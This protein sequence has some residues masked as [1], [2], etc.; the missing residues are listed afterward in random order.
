MMKRL[1]NI[2]KYALLIVFCILIRFVPR[3]PNVEPVMA[4]ILPVSKSHGRYAALIFGIFVMI[5]FDLLTSFGIW[6][7]ITAATYG[8]VGF[9]SAYYFKDREATGM[10]FIKFAIPATIAYDFITA[11]FSMLPFG[12]SLE[13]I[14]LG[15]I[16]FTIMH[17]LGNVALCFFVSPLLYRYITENKSIELS[18]ILQ[19]K[20]LGAKT[21]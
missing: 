3:I 16:P 5:I 4:S 12:M 2:F 1:N 19:R 14:W 10:N 9:V 21:A 6:T 17:L 8:I 11:T 15:Q 13:Q 7:I 18:S 20:P